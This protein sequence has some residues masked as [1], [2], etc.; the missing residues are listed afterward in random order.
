M[1]ELTADTFHRA[2]ADNPTVAC[3]LHHGA[4][5]E[6]AEKAAGAD[7]DDSPY[8]W[9]RIDVGAAPDIGAM[10]RVE[11]EE[12]TLL[13]MRDGVVLYCQPLHARSPEATRAILDRAARLDMGD[14][15]REVDQGHLGR[16][17]L[18]NRRA[19]PTTWRTR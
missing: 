6:A 16:D 18:L 13:V 10:F 1:I 15:R 2:M 4:F 5:D 19:C 12:P 11:A 8:T 9:T 3:I 7:V 17:A 14:I